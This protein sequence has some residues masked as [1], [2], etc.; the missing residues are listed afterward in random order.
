MQVFIA[1]VMGA[2]LT[3]GGVAWF[4]STRKPYERPIVNWDK[5]V[6]KR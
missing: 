2:V 3:V 4:D 6:D 1:A 5:F